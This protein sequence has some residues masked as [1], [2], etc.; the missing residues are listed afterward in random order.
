M[1]LKSILEF[2]KKLLS[3]HNIYLIAGLVSGFIFYLIA[4]N[5]IILLCLGDLPIF[6]DA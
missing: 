4:F 1:N 6:P 3:C 2:K 5:M